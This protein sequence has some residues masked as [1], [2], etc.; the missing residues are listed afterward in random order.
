MDTID[1]MCIVFYYAATPVVLIWMAT[2][3]HTICF[4]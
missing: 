4:F 2:I 1:T 3:V